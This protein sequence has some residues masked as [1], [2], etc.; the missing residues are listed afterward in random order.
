MYRMQ[1]VHLFWGLCYVLFTCRVNAVEYNVT[2][3]HDGPVVLG[4]TITFRAD[5]FE[6][7]ERPSGTFKYKW[8]DN[9]LTPHEY[10]TEETSNTTTYWSL[11]ISPDNYTIGIYEVEVIVN[12]KP[13][14]F[15]WSRLTSV[16]TTF[17]VTEFL[18][19]DIVIIQSNQTLMDPYVSSL[20]ETNMTINI[21]KGD[22]DYLNKATSV[23]IYWFIDCKYYGQTSD[24]YFLYN[25]TNPDTS[26]IVEALVVAS[27][28]LLT[29]TTLPPTTVPVTTTISLNITVPNTTVSS[30]TTTELATTVVSNSYA[31]LDATTSIPLI[32]TL[33]SS[34][35][36]VNNISLPYICSNSSI[37]PPDP[38]KTY[39]HFIKKID[40]RAPI[41]NISVEGTNWIQ[42]WDMLSLNVTCKGSG[43][44]YKCLYFHRGKYNV[45]GNETCDNGVPIYPCNFSIIHYFLEPSVYTILIILHNDVSKQIY[46]LTINIYKVTT[47]PQLSVIVVPVSC[48]LAAVVLIIFG[49]AYYIQSRARFTVEVADFDFGQNNPELEYKTFTERL[50]DSFNNAITPGSK[51]ISGYK[52][53]NNSQTLQ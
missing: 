12:G 1:I 49:I 11:N 26:H 38:N 24:L 50:R 35:S 52:P 53:L 14:I 31:T 36:S 4:G 27:Y 51:R 29:T 39:G 13:Y 40:I 42:P 43:P 18:N 8:K 3:S 34:M 37:I 25:F 46:P 16:R 33:N 7:G 23:F 48:S 47:K 6:N 19:G 5:L 30:I 20:S 21:R 44:F 9:A 22:L 45:T 17:Y 2:L 28:D 32:D 15:L 41:M 10:E